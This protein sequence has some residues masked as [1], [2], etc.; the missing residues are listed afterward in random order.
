MVLSQTQY[1]AHRKALGLPGS[2][3]NSVQNAIKSGRLDG[4]LTADRK[5]IADAALADRLWAA[6]TRHNR[7]PKGG[8]TA[9]ASPSSPPANA[10]PKHD[11]AAESSL[12]G[13]PPIAESLARKEA[14]NAELAE[15]KLAADKGAYLEVAAV[16]REQ[17]KQ[18]AV[19]QKRL[20]AIPSELA[21]HL[22]REDH[23][24]IA[25]IVK[26]TIRAALQQ[27]A[28]EDDYE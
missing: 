22:S 19:I 5:A 12:D 15:R 13:V 17:L 6:N 16:R 9:A 7:R 24:R 10:V 11:A 28:D 3:L 2:H 1:A 8:P 26:R 27:L 25:P 18:N 23:R 4:A 21:T 20:L 14:A